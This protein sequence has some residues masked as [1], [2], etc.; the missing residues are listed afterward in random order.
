MA[1]T[2]LT[3]DLIA[4]AALAILDNN[5]EVRKTLWRD[6]ERTYMQDINGY[7]PGATISIRRPPDYT[8]RTGA[9][10][11]TQDSIEGKVSLTVDIQKGVDL[12]FPSTAMTLDVRDFSDRYL[13]S[14]MTTLAN[15][16]IH[17]I[18]EEF[19]NSTYNAV[20]TPGNKVRNYSD[21]S[22]SAERL[23]ELAAP[24]VDRASLLNPSDHWSMLGDATTLPGFADAPSR[25]YRQ[26]NIGTVAAID[27]YN[28]AIT[29]TH[30]NGTHAGTPTVSGAGQS[31]LY[32]AVKNTWSQTLNTTGW[33]I[34]SAGVVKRGDVFTIAGVNMVNPKT[35][36]DTGI[37]QQFVVNADADADGSGDAALLISPPIIITG[38]HQQVTA[39]P[40]DAAAMTMSGTASQSIKTS[41]TYHEN[42]MALAV[43]PMD[44]PAGAYQAAR[45]THDDLSIRIVPI[46]DGV[47]DISKWRTDIL[48][49]RVCADPRIA[50]RLYGT[51]AP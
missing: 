43:V 25:A 21:F 17:D 39:A 20:G 3:T 35:K 13:K 9:P 34:S 49:G 5:L 4:R 45:A 50:T 36:A 26:A 37:A 23:D 40:A 32:D 16:V 14:A 7:A 29:P 46:Y 31:V 41:M 1:N 19:M 27:M 8:V 10:I 51:P 28:S 48:Y 47:N 18:F 38:P 15:D 33:T 11:S 22:A 24:S 6:P 2:V 44:L 30:V 42:A 12:E